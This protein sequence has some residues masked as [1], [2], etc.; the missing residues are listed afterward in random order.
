[1]DDVFCAQ[2]GGT[3][4]MQMRTRYGIVKWL[5]PHCEVGRNKIKSK[6]VR[7]NEDVEQYISSIV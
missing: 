4:E 7:K 3:G 1:M 5:C 2:C 6:G